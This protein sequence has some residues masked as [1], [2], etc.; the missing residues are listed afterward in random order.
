VTTQQ[1]AIR[2]TKLVLMVSALW[3]GVLSAGQA[4]AGGLLLYEVGTADVGLAS[5]GWGARAQ[6]ASAILT[7]PAGMTRLDRLQGDR[8]ALARGERWRLLHYTILT[9]KQDEG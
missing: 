8:K 2:G 6:D 5:A 9:K 4:V 1:R 3:L 7:D